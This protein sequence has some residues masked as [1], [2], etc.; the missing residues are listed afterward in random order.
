MQLL[1]PMS[2]R[3]RSMHC[4]YPALTVFN[5]FIAAWLPELCPSSPMPELE[6]HYSRSNTKLLEYLHCKCLQLCIVSETQ[7]KD[8]K[9]EKIIIEPE[10]NISSTGIISIQYWFCLKAPQVRK[11]RKLDGRCTTFSTMHSQSRGDSK[12]QLLYQSDDTSAYIITRRCRPVKNF[13]L[14]CFKIQYKL[15]L[16]DV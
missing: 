8:R 2:V 10:R 9:A 13:V 5:S 12:A 4:R 3:K 6:L 11:A 1:C 16:G 7:C 14:P 15:D